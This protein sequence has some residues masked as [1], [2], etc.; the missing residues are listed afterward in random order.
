MT[1]SLRARLTLFGFVATPVILGVTARTKSERVA[2]AFLTLVAAAI[3]GPILMIIPPHIEWGIM[4]GLTA[5]YWARK[6]WV[7]EYVVDSFEGV[8]PRCHTRLQVAKGTTLRFPHNV[9]CYQCHEHPALELGEAPP[10]DPDAPVP[11]P[12]PVHKIGERRP[13]KIWSP[14]GS[15]W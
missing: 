3:A 4:T 15:D 12:R 10:L 5:I 1:E 6:H 14:A 9:A 11:E 8:C 7:A 13:L 2:R